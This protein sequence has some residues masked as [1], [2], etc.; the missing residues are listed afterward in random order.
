[1]APNAPGYAHVLS[2]TSKQ[3]LR[4]E[5]TKAYVAPME[6]RQPTQ[7]EWGR[8]AVRTASGISR[9]VVFPGW[10]HL[11]VRKFLR[12]E[13][14][15]NVAYPGALGNVIYFVLKLQVVY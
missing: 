6:G 8:P 1:M 12:M 4:E 2:P 14:Y 13:D 15:R 5:D 11:K 7:P 9:D 3:G 10:L